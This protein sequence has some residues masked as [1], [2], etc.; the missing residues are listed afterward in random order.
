MWRSVSGKVCLCSEATSAPAAFCTFLIIALFRKLPH[1]NVWCG[2]A[3]DCHSSSDSLPQPL[4]VCATACHST[5]FTHRTVITRPTT[6]AAMVGHQVEKGSALSN[7]SSRRSMMS[8]CVCVCVMSRLSLYAHLL[9]HEFE[10]R[11]EISA[12]SARPTISDWTVIV[13]ININSHCVHPQPE[14]P[15]LLHLLHV[16]HP[17]LYS[18]ALH[19][20]ISMA[21]IEFKWLPRSVHS[22]PFRSVPA[23]FQFT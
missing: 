14:Q 1:E 2:A 16:P 21:T 23:Y 19:T 4:V 5:P 12:C 17:S 8:V 7:R 18:S 13:I 3:T 22:V 20:R 9:M 15:P 11:M 10:L 6:T